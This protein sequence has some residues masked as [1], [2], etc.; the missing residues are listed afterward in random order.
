MGIT[1]WLVVLQE[2]GID[3]CTCTLEAVCIVAIRPDV[4]KFAIVASPTAEAA[5]AKAQWVL[6]MSVAA[7]INPLSK[8]VAMDD[9]DC[10]M[11][12]GPRLRVILEG[13]LHGQYS[14]ASDAEQNEINDA[15]AACLLRVK[16]GGR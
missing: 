1:H 14:V 13:L 10:I 9:Y 6:A 4:L 12:P 7:R 11:A 5:M 3:A 2:T 16:G 8:Y 15:V